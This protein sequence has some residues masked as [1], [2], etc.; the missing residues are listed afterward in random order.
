MY[1]AVN[2]QNYLLICKEA[3]TLKTTNH[4][5]FVQLL[6]KFY[7]QYLQMTEKSK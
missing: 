5:S 4:L 7:S 2:Q 1:C 3:S 6:P